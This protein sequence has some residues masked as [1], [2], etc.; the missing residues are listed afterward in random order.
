M[1]V[2]SMI[3]G[4]MSDDGKPDFL[5]STFSYVRTLQWFS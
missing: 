2:I 1:M 5:S 4:M 3:V